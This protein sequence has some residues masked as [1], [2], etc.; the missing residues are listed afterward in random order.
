MTNPEVLIIGGGVSGL[1]TAWW[2]ADAGVSVEIWE[3]ED[4]PGGKIGSRR[5]AGYLLEQSA[6]MVMNFRPE[7]SQFMEATGLVDSKSR[8]PT[9][10]TRY[11]VRQGRLMVV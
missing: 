3:Q 11:L 1:A 7:V 10:P 2:L 8:G 9:K 5:E 4:R 6:S